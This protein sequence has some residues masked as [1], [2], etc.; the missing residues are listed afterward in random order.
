VASEDAAD[1][2]DHQASN[3][4]NSR[5]D[6]RPGRPYECSGELL[7]CI[8]GRPGALFSGD[9]CCVDCLD[10][11]VSDLLVARGVARPQVFGD[12][13]CEVEASGP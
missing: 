12:V 13:G 7:E 2:G 10:R 11:V 5:P 8:G 4:Q 9:L 6:S 3:D 1:G